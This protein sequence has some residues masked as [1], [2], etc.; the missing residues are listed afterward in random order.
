MVFLTFINDMWLYKILCDFTKIS[1]SSICQLY[2]WKIPWRRLWAPFEIG[3]KIPAYMMWCSTV[4]SS[5]GQRRH[6][7]ITCTN[8][9]NNELYGW[10]SPCLSY[11]WLLLKYIDI[12]SIYCT[13]LCNCYM[14]NF[15]TTSALKVNTR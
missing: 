10:K 8:P 12:I 14:S 6:T 11:T 2:A 13:S 1:N 7:L 5:M 3:R 4:K 15:F 9:C